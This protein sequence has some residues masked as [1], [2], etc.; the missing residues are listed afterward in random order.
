MVCGIVAMISVHVEPSPPHTPHAS[1]FDPLFAI[2]SHPTQVA[3]VPLQTPVEG[4]SITIH[5]VRKETNHK[6]EII[7]LGLVESNEL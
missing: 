2:L 7:S 5:I 3:L 6:V 4:G 1:F